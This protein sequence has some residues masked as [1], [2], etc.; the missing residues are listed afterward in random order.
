LGRRGSCSLTG[1]QQ[2]LI[3]GLRTLASLQLRPEAA[4]GLVTRRKL[5]FQL[6]HLSFQ[7]SLLRRQILLDVALILNAKLAV[8]EEM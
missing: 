8:F 1:L 4:D 7:L 6:L 5:R 2:R 3:R